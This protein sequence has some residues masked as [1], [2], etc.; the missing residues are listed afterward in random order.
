MSA[1]S[2][3]GVT[4]GRGASLHGGVLTL[5]RCRYGHAVPG[6]SRQ[7]RA[8]LLGTLLKNPGG[9]LRWGYKVCCIWYQ[10]RRVISTHFPSVL[11]RTWR[12]SLCLG[13]FSPP[14]S[15]AP[16]EGGDQGRA[17]LWVGGEDDCLSPTFLSAAPPLPCPPSL[18]PH[19]YLT[20]LRLP[21]TALWR[22]ATRSPGSM[23]DQSKEKL[24]WRWPR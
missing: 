6:D 11:P 5:W 24:R 17:G 19:R 12:Q 7:L 22:L 8:A 16:P 10:N 4:V 21:W 1:D 9:A 15:V 14:T 18:Y 13:T 20:T 23:A 3:E 2:A